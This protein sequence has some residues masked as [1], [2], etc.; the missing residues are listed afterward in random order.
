MLRKAVLEKIIKTLDSS[1]FTASDFSVETP[2]NGDPLLQLTFRHHPSYA[3]ILKEKFEKDADGEK[4][5]VFYVTASPGEHKLQETDN[6]Y[7]F[8]D[9]IKGITAWCRNIRS[10]LRAAIPVFDDI[11]ILRAKIEEHIKEHVEDP[12]GKFDDYELQDIRAKFEA[13]YVTLEELKEHKKVTEA[14]L[15]KLK[16]ELQAIQEDAKY[17]PRGTW[18]K[19]A[20]NKIFGTLTKVAASKEG[21]GIIADSARKLI[22]LE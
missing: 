14:E 4:V 18:L 10:E 21:R 2:A 17:Y 15:N 20:S 8:S 12:E 9:V 19:T 1:C 3:Y 11:D 22:G 6:F 7:E 5:S 13:L 16:K